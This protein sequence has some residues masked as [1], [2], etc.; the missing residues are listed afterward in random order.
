M[1]HVF[2]RSLCWWIMDPRERHRGRRAAG[3]VFLL[4]WILHKLPG[5]TGEWGLQSCL[6]TIHQALYPACGYVH[7]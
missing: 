3:C 6:C 7:L 5:G 2:K 1:I 4:G